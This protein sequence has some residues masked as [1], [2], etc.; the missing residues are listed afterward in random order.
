MP[1]NKQ[2]ITTGGAGYIPSAQDPYRVAKT[3]IMGYINP[4]HLSIDTV[5]Q[6]IYN[7]LYQGYNPGL[8]G[9][10]S[11]LRS[12]RKAVAKNQSEWGNALQNTFQADEHRQSYMDDLFA[13]YLK[14][15]KNKRRSGN[16]KYGRNLVVDARYSP[17]MGKSGNYKMLLGGGWSDGLFYE[18]RSR[19]I[20]AVLKGE[21]EDQDIP[22]GVPTDRRFAYFGTPIIPHG[23][24]MF[25][26]VANSNVLGNYG[27]GTHTI[28]RGVDPKKGDYVSY[29]DLWDMAPLSDGGAKDQSFGIGTPFELYDRVYLDDYYGV[30]SSVRGYPKGTYYGGWIPEI[31]I[32]PRK[33]D[34][35]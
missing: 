16:N 32:K 30:D 17:S 35:R 7:N 6:R 33:N 25:G 24:L 18:D 9:S 27:L 20:Q 10:E 8:I 28:S 4:D 1:D 34:T 12:V 11:A 21:R 29:Y 5:R 3:A 15:P 22:K 26:Q 23:P 31:T 13:E 14:I 2:I 19:L